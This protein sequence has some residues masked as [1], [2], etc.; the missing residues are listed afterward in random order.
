MYL[1][2]GQDRRDLSKTILGIKRILARDQTAISPKKTTLIST[3]VQMLT[4]AT[5][6][7]TL[8]TQQMQYMLAVLQNDLAYQ[9][10]TPAVFEL[11]LNLGVITTPSVISGGQYGALPTGNYAIVVID[12]SNLATGAVLTCHVTNTIVNNVPSSVVDGITI[13]SGGTN[14]TAPVAYMLGNAAH[15]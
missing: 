5:P 14:Y 7:G 2:R 9:C 12:P 8:Q 6:P 15:L 13:V 3:R 10:T 4:G 1:F 11:N